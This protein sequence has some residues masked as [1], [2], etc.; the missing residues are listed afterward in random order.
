MLTRY[1]HTVWHN[2]ALGRGPLRAVTLRDKDASFQMCRHG[3]GQ[4]E[5]NKHVLLHCTRT[6]ELRIEAAA[7]L[8]NYRLQL[9]VKNLLT[10]DATR[11]LAEKMILVFIDTV[12]V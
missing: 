6:A 12:H 2:L 7:I 4:I 8:T 1:S 5:D 10:H 11:E 3:C 9:S